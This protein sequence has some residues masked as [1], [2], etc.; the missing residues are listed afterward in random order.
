MKILSIDIGIINL[1]Y[2]F[3][4]VEIIT[5]FS[6]SKYKNL[7]LNEN[8]KSI[9]NSVN[10]IDCNRIDITNVKHNTVKI[11][12]CLLHH[13]RCI[14]DYLDHFI[15]EKQNLFDT[16]DIILIERQPPVGIT[17]VQ[18]LLFTKFRSK[19]LLIS[20]NSV[21]KY[22]KLS[23]EYLVRK[24]ESEKISEIYLSNFTNFSNNIRKHDISDALLMIIF[25]YKITNDKNIN[26]T[27]FSK[28]I[29]DN[30]DQFRFKL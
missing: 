1:G 7:K 22:F 24:I 18:D 3:A 15:Q 26:N 20:P 8:Y 13:E 25:Y 16:A 19:V 23:S 21:H 27:D 11:C 6:G 28:N 5:S 10:V 30:F 9:T 14:P 12:D 17:N 2:V 29:T 4:E